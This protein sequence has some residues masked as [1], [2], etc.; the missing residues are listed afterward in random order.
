[1][2]KPLHK[3]LQLLDYSLSWDYTVYTYLSIHLLYSSALELLDKVRKLL[4]CKTGHMS[5]PNVR[6]DTVSTVQDRL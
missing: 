2:Y 1:M 4:S 3:Y 5:K 6:V